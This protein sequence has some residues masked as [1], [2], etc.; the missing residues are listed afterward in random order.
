LKTDLQTVPWIESI[1]FSPANRKSK[2]KSFALLS[3]VNVVVAGA[4]M[5]VVVV[6]VIARFSL[7]KKRFKDF[8]KNRLRLD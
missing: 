8:K 4:I 2:R 1:G 3:H 6:V 7:K 5:V